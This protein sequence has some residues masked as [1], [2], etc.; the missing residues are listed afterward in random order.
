MNHMFSLPG[1][2]RPG[3]NDCHMQLDKYEAAQM[4]GIDMGVHVIVSNGFGVTYV[5]AGDFVEAHRTAVCAYEKTYRFDASE[6]SGA[7]ADIVVTGSSAPTD[8]LF[9]HTS[10]AVVNCDPL[11][12]DGGTIIQA[13]PCPGY[14]DWPGFALM[15]L[16]VGYMPPSP[17][18]IPRA[19]KA[20]Y[21]KDRELWAG[22]IW[23]KVYEVMTRK[24][25]K[26]VTNENN[27]ELSRSVGL[28]SS[29][30]LQATFDEALRSHGPKARVVFVPYGR[31]SVF[32]T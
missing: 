17:E 15:D 16:L 4:V 25:V 18:N 24:S 28:D 21:A 13:T 5:I 27:L 11:C 2:C 14:G 30:S 6:F 1:D 3:N 10:W 26:I 9:F 12:K 20:F 23:W 32:D 31:Y 8:H 29:A 19:L 22:C 7:P